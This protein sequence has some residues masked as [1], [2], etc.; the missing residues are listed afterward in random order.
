MTAFLTSIGSVLTAAIGWVGNVVS[1]MFGSEGALADLVPFI[2]LGIGV[3]ILGLGVG[4][5]RSFIK[6]GN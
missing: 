3:G 1:A 4:Y 6:I 5:I 2:A